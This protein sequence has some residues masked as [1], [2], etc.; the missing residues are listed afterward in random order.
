MLLK[1]RFVWLFLRISSKEIWGFVNIR[2][3]Q[4]DSGSASRVEDLPSRWRGWRFVDW[5]VKIGMTWNVV[6]G[7]LNLK[8]SSNHKVLQLGNILNSEES[9]LIAQFLGNFPPGPLPPYL[10]FTQRDKDSL[11]VSTFH[12]HSAARKP[13]KIKSS[14]TGGSSTGNVCKWADVKRSPEYR[15][16]WSSSEC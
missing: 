6:L 3:I 7:F 15:N 11:T 16:K 8:N 9:K 2:G 5:A 12:R 1:A 14:F 10:A 4:S 13:F